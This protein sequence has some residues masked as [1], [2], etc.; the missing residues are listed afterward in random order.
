MIKNL[1]ARIKRRNKYKVVKGKSKKGTNS[2]FSFNRNIKDIKGKKF[3]W[4]NTIIYFLFLIVCFYIIVIGVVSIYKFAKLSFKRAYRDD[5]KELT[6]WRAEDRL[7]ILL[8]GI[9]KREGEFGY[10]DAVQILVIDPIDKSVG[11]FNINP[12]VSVYISNIRKYTEIRNVYNQGV[13]ESKEIPIYLLTKSVENLVSVK[14]HRYIILDEDSMIKLTELIGGIYVNNPYDVKDKDVV[15]K[16]GEF[17]LEKGNFRLRSDQF[18]AYLRTDDDSIDNKLNRQIIGTEGLLKKL[19][20]YSIFLKSIK[21]LENIS[22]I[23]TTNL[24]KNEIVRLLLVISKCGEIKSS[25][26]GGNTIQSNG[27][28]FLPIYDIL[29]K[30]IQKVFADKSVGKEQARVEVFNSTDIKGLANFRARWL[31]NIGIDVIRIGD[32][33][34]AFDKTTVYTREED[35]YNDTLNS[36][37]RSFGEEIEIR[38]GEMPD[39]FCTGDVIII[40]GNNIKI[41]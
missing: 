7:N 8:V 14:I 24:S 22:D 18:L 27:E 5:E 26:M 36:I 10:I 21:I 13:L 28:N 2:I 29:D 23:L 15:L 41:E 20:S 40:L 9:D 4:K 39:W 37:K 31:R 19:T 35:K 38:D 11:I 1:F 12:D 16:N 3:K 30:E 6:E 34:Q 32:A 25:F 33:A 17:K